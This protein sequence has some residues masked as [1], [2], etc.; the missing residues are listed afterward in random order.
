MEV[1][2]TVSPDHATALQPGRQSKTPSIKK[3]KK[4]SKVKDF[5]MSLLAAIAQLGLGI[6][7]HLLFSALITFWDTFSSFLC[8]NPP[9]GS[10]PSLV[11]TDM[12]E[13]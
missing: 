12:K 5:P 10:L 4:G 2:V 1:K 3:K 13:P 8:F 6:K 7:S 9:N 11:T